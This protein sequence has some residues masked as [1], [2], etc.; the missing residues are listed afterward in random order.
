VVS[1]SDAKR[2]AQD[3]DPREGEEITFQSDGQII[4]P[5]Y[6]S[7]GT[8]ML[9]VDA[10]ACRKK[11]GIVEIAKIHSDDDFNALYRLEWKSI[12]ST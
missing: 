12:H 8:G 11:A 10:W 1:E 3:L 5:H 7:G 2:I 6:H 4:N 9:H